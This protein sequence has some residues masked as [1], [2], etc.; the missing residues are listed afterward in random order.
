M[1]RSDAGQRPPTPINAEA[2]GMQRALR[3]Y[4]HKRERDTTEGEGE[5]KSGDCDGSVLSRVFERPVLLPSGLVTPGIYAHA[6]ELARVALPRDGH[7][8]CPA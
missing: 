4:L 5:S 8:L 6:G 1:T 3:V 2:A 7:L